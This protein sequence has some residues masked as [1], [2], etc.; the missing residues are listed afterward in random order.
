MERQENLMDKGATM[1]KDYNFRG[2][3]SRNISKFN[4]R[5]P[6]D[7]YAEAIAFAKSLARD[8]HGTVKVNVDGEEDAI[9]Y[10]DGQVFDE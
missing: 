7:T 1:S 8:W 6:F 3:T 5:C 4:E 2:A 9:V 10:E